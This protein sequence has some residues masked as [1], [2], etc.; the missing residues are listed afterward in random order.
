MT[1]EKQNEFLLSLVNRLYVEL[2]AYVSFLEWVKLLAEGEDID[3]IL[4]K[5]RRDPALQIHVDA[6]LRDLSAKLIQSDQFEPD[7]AYREFLERWIP[8]GRVN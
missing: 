4:A 6:T 2:G 7:R 5:C 8:K 1:L 3:G